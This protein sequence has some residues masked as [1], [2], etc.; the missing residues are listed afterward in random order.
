M[1]ETS[2][3]QKAD[4]WDNTSEQIHST[5]KSIDSILFEQ[6]HHHHLQYSIAQLL[7]F[8]TYVL[9]FILHLPYPGLLTLLPCFIYLFTLI[10]DAPFLKWH[11]ISLDINLSHVARHL[12]Q[13]TSQKWFYAYFS[14]FFLTTVYFLALF[15]FTMPWHVRI[16]F[17]GLATSIASPFVL[18]FFIA[19]DVMK[20]D[21]VLW[22]PVSR[23]L[24]SKF[25]S[26]QFQLCMML[27]VFK[28]HKQISTR[29]KNTHRQFVGSLSCWP[30]T[31]A[32]QVLLL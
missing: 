1:G 4:L 3:V 19:V 13:Y 32:L 12:A 28:P 5:C 2:I 26:W 7:L 27:H 18:W 23:F 31:V 25:F 15:R 9:C 22:H 6:I 30:N 14:H 17:Q 20:L 24:E 11:C 10:S 8:L 29:N 16:S 21:L